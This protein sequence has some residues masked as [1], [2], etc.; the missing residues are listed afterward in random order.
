M[1]R[2]EVVLTE[3]IEHKIELDAEDRQQAMNRAYGIIM[4]NAEEIPYTTN[5]EGSTNIEVYEIEREE[6]E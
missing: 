5:S 6:G 4:D 2:F 3:S 1:T